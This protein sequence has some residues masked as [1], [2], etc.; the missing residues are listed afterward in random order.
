MLDIVHHRDLRV[1]GEDKVTVHAVYCE[2]R[3]NS[4]LGSGQTLGD[5]GAAVDASCSWGVPQRSGVGVEV[6]IAEC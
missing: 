3:G 6:L 5:Y 4:T 2:V 1:P